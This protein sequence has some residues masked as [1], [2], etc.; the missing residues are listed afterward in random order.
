MSKFISPN[1]R[2]VLYAQS[3]ITGLSEYLTS[4]NHVLNSTATI[5]GTALPIA[6]AT[7]AVGVAIVDGSGNQ[8]TSFGSPTSL[9][10]ATNSSVTPL[11]ANAVFTG[12]TWIDMLNYAEV[13][14]SVFSDVASATNGLVIQ[15]SSDG[16]NVDFTDTYTI[17]AGTGK[18]YSVPRAARYARVVYTNG[19]T[20][21]ATF[22]LQTIQSAIASSSL[23]SQRAQDGQ[24]NETDLVQMQNF[25]MTYNVAGNNWNRAK[26]IGVAGIPAVGVSDGTNAANILKSDGTAAGQNAAMVAGAYQSPTLISLSAG[27]QNSA[28]FDLANYPG[29]S[30]EILTN[31]TPATLTFQTSGDASQTNI[32]SMVLQDSASTAGSPVISTTSALASYYGNRTGRYFRV[33][34]NLAGGNTATIQLTLYTVPIA[35]LTIGGQVGQS[36]TWTVG[37]NSATGSAVPANAFYIGGSLGGNLAGTTVNNGNSDAVPAANALQVSA[38]AYAWDNVSSF[39]RVRNNTTG[40]IL[41]AGQTTTATSATQVSYNAKKLAVIINI[42]AF[43]SGTLTFTVNALTSSGYTYPILVSTALAATGITVLRIFPGATA[44]TNV[45]ANDFVPRS[46]NVVVTGTFSAT[47]GVDYNLGV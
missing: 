47:Y 21:Q 31:T 46:F 20:I 11:G 24:T 44:A 42:S 38:N 7:T 27:T 29:I 41:A 25:N 6:G 1:H 30:L 2:E 34:S 19:G 12:S 37:S 43:V 23:S 15:Q 13:R 16:T 45:A 18:L 32:R 17:A 39:N 4:T 5:S 10:S 33:A 35:P 8:I 3:S 9:V 14:V 40:A 28:W 22:R 26:D 36:G